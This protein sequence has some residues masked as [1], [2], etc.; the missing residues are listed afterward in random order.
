MND[1]LYLHPVHSFATIQ[2]LAYYLRGKV[3]V[4]CNLKAEIQMLGLQ[5]RI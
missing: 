3:A 5:L 4:N 2:Q 1:S